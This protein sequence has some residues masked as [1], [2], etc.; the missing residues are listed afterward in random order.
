MAVSNALFNEAE[1]IKDTNSALED[2]QETLALTLVDSLKAGDHITTPTVINML[3]DLEDMQL[4]YYD[5]MEDNENV[6]GG[7]ENQ[8]QT[9]KE[10]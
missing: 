9:E 8:A 4:K 3:K 1:V 2:V 6:Q 7:L 5:R 10:D